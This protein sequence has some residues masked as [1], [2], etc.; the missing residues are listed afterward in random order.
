VYAARVFNTIGIAVSFLHVIFRL[1]LKKRTIGASNIS[2]VQLVNIPKK[3][4]PTKSIN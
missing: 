4:I 1:L 3:E 2:F